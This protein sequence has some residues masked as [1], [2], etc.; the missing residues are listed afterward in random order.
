MCD[1]VLRH[2]TQSMSSFSLAGVLR[3][4]HVRSNSSKLTS[5]CHSSLV[6]LHCMYLFA[7]PS[8]LFDGWNLE[9]SSPAVVW[10]F[11]DVLPLLF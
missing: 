3:N 6:G 8:P 5:C 7:L 9:H 1:G 10:G 2:V 11:V 4:R